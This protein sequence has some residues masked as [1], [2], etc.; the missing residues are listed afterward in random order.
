[1]KRLAPLD[2]QKLPIR[3]VAIDPLGAP[4]ATPVV[5]QNY[6][7]TA[8]GIG[9]YWNGGS[10]ANKAT[11]ATLLNA[12]NAAFY[13]ARGNHTGTQAAATISD[14]AIVVQAYRLDQFTAPNASLA[15]GGQRIINVADPTGAQDAATKTYVDAQVQLSAAGIDSKPSVRA[16]AT[17]SVV[18]S[19]PQTIDNVALVAGDRVLCVG[20]A[21][22]SQNGVYV[23]AAGAWTRAADADQ[24]GEITPGAQWFVEEGSTNAA[25]QWR[26]A[27]TGAIVLGTTA[28]TIVLSNAA[29]VYTASFGVQKVGNDFRAIAVAGG[30]ITAGAGGLQ[31]DRS[32]V[33]NLFGG[34]FGDGAAL[35]YVIA[36]NLATRNVIVQ[37]QLVATNEAI[38]CDWDAT[39]TMTIT[40]KNFGVAP[41]AGA[42][43]VTVLG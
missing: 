17:A 15:I 5:G 19:G 33:P 23:V 2:M 26:T 34:V 6:F 14:L 36:H 29:T 35:S 20:Q 41:A 42:I 38:E 16:I 37:F 4:P 1:M 28:I 13:L 22:A 40:V 11:D 3:N 30:G 9:L 32:M 12:Q 43:R 27:N 18:L 10:W 24:N 7:D 21:I 8:I 25:T 31:V 39:S